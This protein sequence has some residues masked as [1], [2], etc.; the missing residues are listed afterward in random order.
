MSYELKDN[1]L[2]MEFGGKI[3]NN[4]SMLWSFFQVYE[5][6][7]SFISLATNTVVH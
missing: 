7:N 5:H 3:N 1:T 2:C 6:K 4:C